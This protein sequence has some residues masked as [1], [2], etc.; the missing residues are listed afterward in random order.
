M[1]CWHREIENSGTED[2]V[3]SSAR[4]FL[5]LWSSRELAPV[6]LGWRPVSIDSAGDI[7]RM[8]KWVVDDLGGNPAATHLGELGDYLWHASERLREIRT[9]SRY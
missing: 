2:E 6:S 1:D 9:V 7:E 8:K 3:V 5:S 4:D